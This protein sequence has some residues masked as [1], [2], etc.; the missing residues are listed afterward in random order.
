[1]VPASLIA[2]NPG[3]AEADVNDELCEDLC[4]IQQF[5]V[6]GAIVDINS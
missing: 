5:P 4:L 6:A 3:T 2:Q 1:M